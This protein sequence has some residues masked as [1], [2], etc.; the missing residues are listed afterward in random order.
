MDILIC[1]NDVV[2]VR[3][4][5]KQSPLYLASWK[6]HTETCKVL[7][8]KGAAVN[9]PTKVEKNVS[10]GEISDKFAQNING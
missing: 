4:Q 6:G 10:L 8:G 7:L 3:L 9:A 1:L 2:F 5:W